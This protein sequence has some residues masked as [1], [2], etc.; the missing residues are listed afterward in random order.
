M[1]VKNPELH[2]LGFEQAKELINNNKVTSVICNN[3]FTKI[4]FLSKMSNAIDELIYYVDFDLLFS[5]FVVSKLV[6]LPKNVNLIRPKLKDFNQSIT[7]LVRKVSENRCV[8][9]LDSLNGFYN[10][11]ENE[12]SGRLVNSYIMLLASN[13]AVSNSRILL[14]SISKY[15]KQ[16]GWT[17]VPTGRHLIENEKIKKLYLEKKDSVLSIS[18]IYNHGTKDV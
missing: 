16:E 9:I 12:R 15:K 1:L 3:P 13:T 17:L 7:E 6:S 11:F 14:M 4:Y 18:R 5:G 8:V 2:S 10:L